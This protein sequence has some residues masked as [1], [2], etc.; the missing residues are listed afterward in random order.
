MRACC[1]MHDACYAAET[2]PCTEKSWLGTEG[3][4]CALCNAEVVGCM[5]LCKPFYVPDWVITQLWDL[6]QDLRLIDSHDDPAAGTHKVSAGLLSRSLK[7]K[8]SEP[9][10]F[11]TEFLESPAIGLFPP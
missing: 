2:P 9:Q 8:N 3:L 11:P 1:A 5:L 4:A 10:T 7:F 6:F